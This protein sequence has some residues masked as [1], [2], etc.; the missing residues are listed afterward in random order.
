MRSQIGEMA[1]NLAGLRIVSDFPLSWLPLCSNDAAEEHEVA[2][3]RSDV[4]KA[5][6]SVVAELP[7]AQ[8]NG[9]ELLLV[10]PEA[11]RFLLRGGS[12]ILIDPAPSLDY[13][14]LRSYLLGTAFGALCHQRGILPLHSS[15]IERADGCVAFV[16]PKG[17]GKSTLAA[18]LASR[19]HQVLADDVCFLRVDDKGGIRTW[20]GL[21]RIRLWQDTLTALGCGGPEV[22]REL[23]GDNKYLIPTASP[24]TP[25]APRRLRGVYQLHTTLNGGGA[26]V[27]RI[28][29]AKAI[30][31][32]VQNVY[33]L[34]LA[35]CMGYKPAAF[36]ACAATAINVP[37]F[38]FS[39]PFGFNL[40]QE[41][42]EFLEDHWRAIG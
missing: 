10:S 6:S 37:V 18:A 23:G 36:A 32:L 22:E 21:S 9:N 19:G 5:L 34:N 26:S 12:E 41:G 15:V 20:P 8:Y 11:G 28:Q 42:V 29:G 33:R 1:Y 14:E 13:G 3:R 40:L 38:Q 17:A 24:R 35:A 2:I 39:R 25:S 16:G 30:E 31:V 27:D 7:N 4:P